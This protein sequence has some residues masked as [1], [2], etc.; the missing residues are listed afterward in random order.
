MILL[1]RHSDPKKKTIYFWFFKII[2]VAVDF[3]YVYY[4]ILIKKLVNKK[5]KT[6]NA[7]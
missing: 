7:D 1:S 3:L 6:Q 5:W 2:S 4:A